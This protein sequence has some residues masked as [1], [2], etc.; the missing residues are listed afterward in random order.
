M[1]A[2]IPSRDVFVLQR[3]LWFVDGTIVTMI[4][5]AYQDRSD[6]ERA[7]RDVPR[8]FPVCLGRTVVMR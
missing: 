3:H 5:G 8:R 2:D 4:V 1:T 7:A 6:C